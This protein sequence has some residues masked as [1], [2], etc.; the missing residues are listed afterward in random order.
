MHKALAVLAALGIVLAVSSGAYA[1]RGLLT[2][3]DIKDGS[4]TGADIAQHSLGAS[5]L[6]ASARDALAGSEGPRGLLG[7]A[8]PDGADG[9]PGMNG[10]QGDNGLPGPA[11]GAGL[12][13]STG[14]VGATGAIGSTGSVGA[15]G[16]TGAIGST[17]VGATGVGG[18]AGATGPIGVTGIGG[19]SGSTGATGASGLDGTVTPLA[20]TGGVVALPTASP[21]VTVV[22]LT[23]PAGRYIILAKTQLAQ[24]GAGDSIDCTLKTGT[25]TLDQ[26]SLKT[27]PALA[28]GSV[29]LQ[30][31]TTTG[32]TSQLSVQCLVEVANG[33]ANF[34]SLIAIPTN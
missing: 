5:L 4:L 19:A 2:G 34:S 7:R 24:T 21:P 22:A 13:G 25:T 29:S 17:G 3:R 31:V 14:S 10:R 27:L 16:A 1:A 11:G 23:V 20:A 26:S 18:T 15:T 33:T 8:G 32:A 12:T 6:S 30:A 28:A 9:S